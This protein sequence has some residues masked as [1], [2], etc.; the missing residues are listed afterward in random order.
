MRDEDRRRLLQAV[1]LC[2]SYPDETF[3]ASLGEIARELEPC[4]GA[5][6][7]RL[8]EFVDWLA[9]VSPLAAQEHY[10]AVFDLN[11]GT[12]L[13]LTWHLTGDTEDRGRALAALVD[14]YRG[15]GFDIETFELPDYLPLV[16]EFLA[17]DAAPAPPRKPL[18]DSLASLPA[19]AARLEEAGSVYAPLLA[20]VADIVAPGTGFHR[21]GAED[22]EAGAFSPA[23]ERPAGGKAPAHATEY[24]R[25]PGEGSF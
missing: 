10:T 11:P 22:A 15:A 8:R 13:N 16:L 2:L 1:S 4:R 20:L 17:Q 5:D 12:S 23:G 25:T 18:A 3:L 6:W 9:A 24:G 7:D 19:L 14:V 21:R